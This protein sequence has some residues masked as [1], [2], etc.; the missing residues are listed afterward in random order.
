MG[1]KI[2]F[3]RNALRRSVQILRN[4]VKTP[5]CYPVLERQPAVGV[6]LGLFGHGRGDIPMFFGTL[7]RMRQTAT[8]YD[9]SF[10]I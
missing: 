2:H 8:L 9:A 5:N 4:Y 1:A 10:S 6:P 7:N 3:N